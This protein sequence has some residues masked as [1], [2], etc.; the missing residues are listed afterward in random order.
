MQ[1]PHILIV[2]DE[3]VTRNTLKSIFEA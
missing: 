2:E 1:T 3:L